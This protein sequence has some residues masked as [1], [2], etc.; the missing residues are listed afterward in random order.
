ME[1]PLLLLWKSRR[2]KSFPFQLDSLSLDRLYATVYARASEIFCLT[3]ES[4]FSFSIALALKLARLLR[5]GSIMFN[6]LFSPSL[7]LPLSLALS[8][9]LIH[10]RVFH[11]F[12]WS[13]TRGSNKRAREQQTT[14]KQ[15]FKSVSVLLRLPQA[16]LTI[17]LHHHMGDCSKV[18][19]PS[20]LFLILPASLMHHSLAFCEPTHNSQQQSLPSLM[21]W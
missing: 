13:W 7:G 21:R 15:H 11:L 12:G 19:F 17:V 9:L 16:H 14:Y 20:S 1:N 18:F 2:K 6:F 5:S 3:G 4:S 10:F 8:G